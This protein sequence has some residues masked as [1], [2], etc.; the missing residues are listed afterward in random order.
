MPL[1][2]CFKRQESAAERRLLRLAIVSESP[3]HRPKWRKTFFIRRRVLDDHCPK[4]FRV[5][6]KHSKAAG[7]SV[8][9]HEQC[10]LAQVQFFCELL[11]YVNE[12]IKRLLKTFGSRQ[13]EWPN[14]G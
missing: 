3:T 7:I 1:P 2:S 6:R 10:I 8:V 9:L 5:G 14:P 4:S 12:V 13:D 11:N